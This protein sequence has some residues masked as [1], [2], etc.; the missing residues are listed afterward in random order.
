V[1]HV[2][3][4]LEQVMTEIWYQCQECIFGS[5]SAKS[6]NKHSLDSGHYVKEEKERSDENHGD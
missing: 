2:C 1:Q 5:N 6:A 4:H 3:S